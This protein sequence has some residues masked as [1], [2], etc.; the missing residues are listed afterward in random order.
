VTPVD[1]TGSKVD[2]ISSCKLLLL[3]LLLLL[4]I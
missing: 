4:G 3:L 1:A 2:A